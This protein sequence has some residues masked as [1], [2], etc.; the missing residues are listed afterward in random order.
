[1]AVIYPAVYSSD[2]EQWQELVTLGQPSPRC[3]HLGDFAPWLAG[4]REDLTWEHFTAIH[5][6]LMEGALNPSA[7]VPLSVPNFPFQPLTFQF[8]PSLISC[9]NSSSKLALS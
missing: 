3:R 1:M 7:V 8:P 6:K 9:L 4:Y 2:R 5:N